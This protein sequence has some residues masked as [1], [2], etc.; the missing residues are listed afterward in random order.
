VQATIDGE[1]Q[2]S[3]ITGQVEL[4]DGVL[5]SL[6]I[7]LDANNIPFRI[8]GTL[9]LTLAAR[10]VSLTLASET[11]PLAVRGNISIIDGSYLQNVELTEQIRQIGSSTAPST[12]FWE[13]YPLLG[14]ANLKLTL[15]VRR[16]AVRNNIAQIELVGPLIEITNTPRDPR[17]SGSIR[18]QRG[19]FRIPA[20]RAKFTSTTGSIDFAENTRAGDPQLAITSE[21]QYQDLS[22]QQHLIT[23]TLFGALS[24]PQWDLRTS[25]GLNK[26]QTL[27][28]LLTMSPSPSPMPSPL[29]LQSS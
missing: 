18:V 2:V 27:S 11:A 15:D 20:T 12:P 13:E 4:R 17:M 1:G 5:T 10:D 6:G 3:G 9:D 23:L 29:H 7:G 25:T 26:S 14:D 21:A 24:N 22:G 28:L 16:F 19:E 8:P